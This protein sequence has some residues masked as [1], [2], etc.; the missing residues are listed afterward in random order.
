MSKV[1]EALATVPASW[2]GAQAAAALGM[3]SR[4]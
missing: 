1:E 3:A 2:G 4:V